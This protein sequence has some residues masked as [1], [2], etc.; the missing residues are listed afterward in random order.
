MHL[1]AA[2]SSVLLLANTAAACLQAD[3]YY[4][5]DN[6]QRLYGLMKDNDVPLCGIVKQ[7]S[8]RSYIPKSGGAMEKT[9]R[10]Y[11]VVDKCEDLTC[12]D[13]KYRGQICRA[14]GDIWQVKLE[15]NIAP[16]GGEN[17]EPTSFGLKVDDK[18]NDERRLTE[19]V[20]GCSR[21]QIDGFKGIGF[22]GGEVH[23]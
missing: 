5:Q 3:F 23:L 16:E 15:H 8:M 22:P 11:D 9:V 13:P 6:H 19:A 1:T 14:F 2:I 21:E 20:W 17:W 7:G 10:S 4:E 12:K 18:R